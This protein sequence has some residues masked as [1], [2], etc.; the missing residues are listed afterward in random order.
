VLGSAFVGVGSELSGG[1]AEPLLAVP[2]PLAVAVEF[3][4][5]ASFAS[6]SGL[7]PSVCGGGGGELFVGVVISIGSPGE[8]ADIW[9]VGVMIGIVREAIGSSGP[10]TMRGRC[11]DW[12]A[13]V[14]V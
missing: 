3:A 14:I 5:E 13:A 10:S 7:L 11:A 2:G 4:P 12:V 6:W 9:M 1:E 8:G